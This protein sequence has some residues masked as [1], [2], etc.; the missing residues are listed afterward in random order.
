MKKRKTTLNWSALNRLELIDILRQ[1]G[2]KVIDQNLKIETFHQIFRSHIKKHL[3]VKV[4]KNF[5]PKVLR[6]RAYIGGSYYGYL[7]VLNKP[8][9]EIRL[10]YHKDTRY[11]KITKHSFQR[12]CKVFADTVLHELIHMKQYR[13]RE[14][15]ILPDYVS[16]ASNKKKK[17]EQIYLGSSDEIDAYGFNIACELSDFYKGNIKEIIKHLDDPKKCRKNKNDSWNMYLLAFDNNH[18]HPVIKKVKHKVI[19]YL[20]NALKIGKPYKSNNWVN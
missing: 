17:E 5:E 8:C 19:K 2:P 18:S 3:P 6:N 11:L 9:I 14:F 13:K 20:P 12:I 16:T 4:T 15:Q 10:V 7:D 1:L